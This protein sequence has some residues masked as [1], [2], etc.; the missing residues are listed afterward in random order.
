MSY[1]TTLSEKAP[2]E[3]VQTVSLSLSDYDADLSSSC[4]T[5]SPDLEDREKYAGILADTKKQDKAAPGLRFMVW[6]AINVASTVAIVA[7]AAYHFF[8][9]G[10]TLWIISRP[11]CAVFAPK[12]VSVVQIIPLAAAMCIQ[13]ILQNLSLAYSSVMFHQLARLLLTPVVALLNYML[14]STKIPR[15]AISPLILLCSG[16]GIVSYYDSLA[17]DNASTASTPSWGTLFALAGV[18]ASSVYM[19]WIGQY[20]KKFK[21][22][23]MQLLLNQAPVSTVLLLLTVP[24]T[25]TPPLGAVPV[26]MWILILLSGI[27]ASLVNLSQFFIIDLAGPISGTVVG[28][29]KTCI[30]VGLGWAFSTH[31]IYFQSIVGIILA[32]VGMSISALK[33]GVYVGCEGTVRK[34]LELGAPI[35]GKPKT[36]PNDEDEDIDEDISETPLVNVAA[37]RGYDGGLKFLLGYGAS[38]NENRQ[39][40]R[41]PLSLAGQ[42]GHDA[43]MGVLLAREDTKVTLPSTPFSQQPLHFGLER[44]SLDCVL[45]LIERGADLQQYESTGARALHSAIRSGSQALVDF[46]MSRGCNPLSCCGVYV[47]IA[48]CSHGTPA[49]GPIHCSRARGQGGSRGCRRDVAC[50]GRRTENVG[51]DGVTALCW[52]ARENHEMVVDVLLRHGVDPSSPNSGGIRPIHWAVTNGSIPIFKALSARGARIDIQTD[53]ETLLHIA[54]RRNDQPLVETL[55]QLGTDVDKPDNAGRTPLTVAAGGGLLEMMELL[56][57]N[58]ADMTIRDQRN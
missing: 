22:N 4:Y 18:C 46:L 10:A 44:G 17:M 29:L 52:A 53:G 3:A 49:P 12:H 14:Y 42:N 55:I 28:Q 6:T 11:Q 34:C 27:F 24:F 19:V 37:E 13:V 35:D 25:S 16:V 26:S 1:A 38:A 7:F 8:I 21:L 40:A 57:A 51:E 39:F 58:G 45:L 36:D 9:T 15:R 56:L 20:H 32:L 5:E 23:S 31:P 47:S 33:W 2:G 54:V 48:C 50:V 30:I 41:V 43:A